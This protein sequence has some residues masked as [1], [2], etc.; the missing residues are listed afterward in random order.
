MQ[1][2]ALTRFGWQGI[3]AD[4]PRPWD[5]SRYDGNQDA[6][7]AAL[8]DGVQVRLQVR[9]NR[10]PRRRASLDRLVAEYGRTVCKQTKGQAT[11]APLDS[12]V[13][14]PEA[15]QERSAVL[16]RWHAGVSVLGMAWTCAGCGA[17]GVAEVFAPTESMDESEALRILA[18]VS[19]HRP[20]GQRLWSVY[21]FAFLVPQ[22]YNLCRPDMVPGR[23]CFHFRA[24][25]RA[26][27]A[28]GRWSVASQW[29]KKRPLR[30]WPIGL[31][32]ELGFGRCAGSA[33]SPANLPGSDGWRFTGALRRTWPR[34]SAA[35]DALVWH[36]AE[37]DK[38]YAVVAQGGVSGLAE[39]VAATLRRP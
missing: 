3:E 17:L 36:N 14:P 34:A 15:F 21:D 30:D 32:A 16:F 4:V 24:T 26:R 10:R 25:P 35:V 33:V 38:V 23:L 5:L 13:L 39:A 7:F 29:L 12:V 28:V 1:S 19:D 9:W 18:S 6:G 27:L 31:V 11:L 2:A 22:T 37:D 8:D 20:G